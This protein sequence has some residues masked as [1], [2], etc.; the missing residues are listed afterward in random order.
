MSRPLFTRLLALWPGVL[1]AQT[2]SLPP[3]PPLPLPGNAGGPPT[4]AMPPG[5]QPPGELLDIVPPVEIGFWTTRNT[6]LA[7]LCGV[8][9]LGLLIWLLRR[10][11][12]RARPLP[13]PPDPVKTALKALDN[14]SSQTGLELSPKEFAAAVAGVIR[15]F[16]ESKH[17][18]N[19]PRQ[20]TEE[21]LEATERSNRFAL[22]VREQMRLF[23][24]HCDALKFSRLEASEE[25]R[26]DLLKAAYKLVQED[27]L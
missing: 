24:G 14:L 4:G 6:S 8:L 9:L 15:R 27:L 1:L 11:L 10:W 25:A 22:P 7:A 20:T 19:A 17:G 18:L 5:A 2:Q 13:P 12:N 23:L 16:L 21:F 26:K 3:L